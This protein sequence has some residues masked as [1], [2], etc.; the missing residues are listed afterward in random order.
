MPI[1][2]FHGIYRDAYFSYLYVFRLWPMKSMTSRKELD[3]QEC[4]LRSR[5]WRLDTGPMDL[6]FLVCYCNFLSPPLS[7]YM[8]GEIGASLF[9]LKDVLPTLWKSSL[10]QPC[11]EPSLLG[12][13]PFLEQAESHRWEHQRLSNVGM[14]NNLELC[15]E[16]LSGNQVSN[17]RVD[18][19]LKNT[20][21]WLVIALT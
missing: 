8:L 3:S 21:M 5:T 11:S 9:F 12:F 17:L 18:A 7:L 20:W 14:E 1:L 16:H 6:Y 15:V 13:C 19:I 10:L 4:L 2:S